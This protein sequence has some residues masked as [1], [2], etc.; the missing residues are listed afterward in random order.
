MFRVGH[1]NLVNEEDYQIIESDDDLESDVSMEELDYEEERERENQ[2]PLRMLHQNELRT[3]GEGRVFFWTTHA[4]SNLFQI[5]K[6]GIR[7]INDVVLEVHNVVEPEVFAVTTYKRHHYTEQQREQIEKEASKR[8]KY[9]MLLKLEGVLDPENMEKARQTFDVSKKTIDRA[10]KRQSEGK[11]VTGDKRGRKAGQLQRINGATMIKIKETID[12]NPSITQDQIKSELEKTANQ[13]DQQE[14]DEHMRIKVIARSSIGNVIRNLGYSFKRI[15]KQP[16][17]RNSELQLKKRVLWGTLFNNLVKENPIFVFVDECGFSRSQSRDYAYGEIGYSAS[18][19]VDQI[20]HCNNTA[21]A[22]M[23]TGYQMYVEII[24]GAC[25]NE[26]FIEF[27]KNLIVHLKR[28]IPLNRSIIVVMDNARI[29]VRD[30]FNTFWN[31]HIYL[32]KT[33]PYSPQTNG[34]ELTFSQAK[35]KIND[36]M[37]SQSLFEEVYV[38]ILESR[39]DDEYRTKILNI[40]NQYDVIQEFDE[41]LMENVMEISGNLGRY[42][43]RKREIDDWYERE[44]ERIRTFPEDLNPMTYELSDDI[45]HAMIHY[46]FKQITIDNTRHYFAHSIKVADSCIHGYPL[47]MSKKFYEEYEIVD[48]DT[49]MLYLEY[50]DAFN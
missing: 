28:T 48:M 4:I 10:R 13:E 12:N 9:E 21:I 8:T 43:Q 47:S 40:G 29:H 7:N 15:T 5:Y 36:I 20:R 1:N 22:A 49:A 3:L 31:S 25:N 44:K 39:L 42:I 16:Q 11:P 50:S 34:V 41:D 19:T 33:I 26:R 18:V 2:R 23:I 6:N 35:K 17:P 45:F 24:V 37:G 14:I 38:D 32:L 27:C 46:A 30:V